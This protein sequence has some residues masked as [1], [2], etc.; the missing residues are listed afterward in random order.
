MGQRTS[1]ASHQQ[2]A[3]NT[4]NHSNNN[5][6]E[7]RT[8]LSPSDIQKCLSL[9]EGTTFISQQ[10]R[11]FLPN[12]MNQYSILNLD[13]NE[14]LSKILE[15]KILQEMNNPQD[16]T[17]ITRSILEQKLEQ[18]KKQAKERVFALFEPQENGSRIEES[19]AF[20]C[21]LGLMIGDAMGSPFEFS[22]CRFP[23]HVLH[24]NDM[25]VDKAWKNDPEFFELTSMSDVKV[26]TNP[27]YN[28]FGLKPGQY[29]DDSSMALCVLDTFVTKVLDEIY[30][31]A[32]QKDESLLEFDF[33]FKGQDM[34]LRFLNWW[35]FGYNNAFG[36]D[37]TNPGAGSSCGL[38]GNIKQSLLE[39]MKNSNNEVTLA[40][41]SN[42]SGNGSLM[43]NSPVAVVCFKYISSHSTEPLEKVMK[44]AYKHS[45]T[46][47]QGEEAAEL[48]RL[49]T[50]IVVKA[51]KAEVT[52]SP[53]QV[54]QQIF[55]SLRDGEF[56]STLPSV[57]CLVKSQVENNDAT[58]RNWNWLDVNYKFC[59]DR[60]QKDP[61]YCGSY[62]MDAMAMALHNIYY[63]DNFTDAILLTANMRGDS[64]SVAA[65]VGQIAGAIYG[66]QQIP[67]EWIE[68]ILQWDYNND[69]LLRLSM[70]YFHDI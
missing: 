29:T 28:R 65:V 5:N 20:A 17:E 67:R 66:L 3:K 2:P 10:A 14:K 1:T 59:E 61:G 39:F 47:H 38:G 21:F 34:R 19:R 48:C 63:T 13:H 56:V 54:K 68:T 45:K 24:E 41:D 30:E 15:M 43:R 42:T 52:H 6:H 46:T 25:L 62:A 16:H 64:D 40:G 36:K 58:G 11:N 50:F 9:S 8:K 33:D 22:A 18:C 70:I 55:D 7:T 26:W 44:M 27:N 23:R 49:L 69:I 60:V 35:Y 4:T 57:N 31:R 37:E 53:Q 51:V 12:S 32:C